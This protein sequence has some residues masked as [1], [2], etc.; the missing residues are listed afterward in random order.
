MLEVHWEYSLLYQYIISGVVTL[1]SS[2]PMHMSMED[3]PLYITTWISRV[4]KL[5][6]SAPA[7]FVLTLIWCLS[8]PTILQH[9]LSLLLKYHSSIRIT[10]NNVF[11]FY[12]WPDIILIKL[13]IVECRESLKILK[14]INNLRDFLFKS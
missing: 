4:I 10:T 13:R 5:I 3:I 14:F 6:L 7:L 1:V 9:T 11:F 12:S 2:I 8:Q